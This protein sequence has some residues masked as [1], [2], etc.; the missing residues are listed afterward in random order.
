MGIFDVLS[1]KPKKTF[2]NNT[3][4]EKGVLNIMIMN[5]K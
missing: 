4:L 3:N 2:V 5:Q 1:G